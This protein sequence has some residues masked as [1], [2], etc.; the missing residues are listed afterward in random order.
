MNRQ[1]SNKTVFISSLLVLSVVM[2][3]VVL[4]NATA[5]VLAWNKDEN[6]IE[7]SGPSA[8]PTN[9]LDNG[10]DERR[11][12]GSWF[13]LATPT[14]LPLPPVKTLLTFDSDGNALE[15]H[16]L[17]LADSPLGELILTPGHGGWKR[18]G[19]NEFA[20]TL[21]LLYEGGPNNPTSRGVVLFEE[22]LRLKLRFNG[23][24]HLSGEVLDELRD[25]NGNVVF[26]GP[27]TF[28]ATRIAVEPLP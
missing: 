7:R 8:E 11:L 19:N 14:S 27:G 12:V 13:G 26:V 15:A 4:L 1:V 3:A 21:M 22:K 5:P 24:N 25:T 9:N 28:E 17:Y 18:T 10:S 23:Q 16:R 6:K 20:V 2:L